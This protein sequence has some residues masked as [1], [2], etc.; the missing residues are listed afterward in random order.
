VRL[1]NI[2][3][4][5]TPSAS[6]PSPLSFGTLRRLLL[7]LML[8][9]GDAVAGESQNAPRDQLGPI[10]VSYFDAHAGE[11][12]DDLSDHSWN[13][14]SLFLLAKIPVSGQP[15][16]A[17][18]EGVVEV[19]VAKGKKVVYTQKTAVGGTA[20]A[21]ERYVVPVWIT[22]PFCE[23]L[24]IQARLLGQLRGSSARKTVRFRCGE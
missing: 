9:A 20:E 4:Q 5:R 10:T 3:L 22:G 12:S 11:F 1:P 15:G 8:V 2:A 18:R 16:S 6:P 17:V 13:Q 7:S 14:L 24:S 21:S 19:I 23:D